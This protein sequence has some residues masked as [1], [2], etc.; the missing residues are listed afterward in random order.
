[1]VDRKSEN[2][3]PENWKPPEERAMERMENHGNK[4]SFVEYPDA[5]HSF[6]NYGRESNLYF[7]QT[8]LEVEKFLQK[9]GYLDRPSI[10][11]K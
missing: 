8:M 5:G 2:D 1:M 7:R 9:L 10:N 6:F 4:C 3:L 11:V